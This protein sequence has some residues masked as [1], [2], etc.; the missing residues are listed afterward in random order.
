MKLDLDLN[1]IAYLYTVKLY[2][3]NTI[4][5]I[6]NT[7]HRTIKRR[8]KKL[9]IPIRNRETSNVFTKNIIGKQYNN[10]TVLNYISNNF[11]KEQL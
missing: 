3:M 6:F 7:T 5:K 4:G 10:V 11:K 8:L 2:S 1:K 9:G